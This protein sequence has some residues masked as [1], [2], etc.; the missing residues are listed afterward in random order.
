MDDEE[1]L[2]LCGD[3]AAEQDQGLAAR[4]R[5]RIASVPIL[6]QHTRACPCAIARP[7]KDVLPCPDS[8]WMMQPPVLLPQ[9]PGSRTWARHMP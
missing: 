2:V 1:E 6:P 9:A 8:A 4:H 3:T 5:L 7:F